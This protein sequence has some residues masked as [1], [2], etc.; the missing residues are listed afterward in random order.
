MFGDGAL[1]N[2]IDDV[3]N[4]LKILNIKWYQNCITG[5]KVKAILLNIF[6]FAYWWSCIGKGLRVQNGLLNLVSAST[7]WQ[8]NFRHEIGDNIYQI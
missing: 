8:V 5:S 4:F 1:S 3:Q 2:K 6:D 7:A